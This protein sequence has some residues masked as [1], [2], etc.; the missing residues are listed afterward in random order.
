MKQTEPRRHLND[1]TEKIGFPRT[2]MKHVRG[3][4]FGL[5]AAP[6]LARFFWPKFGPKI[7]ARFWCCWGLGAGGAA[8][9]ARGVLRVCAPA[10]RC[11]LASVQR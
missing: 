6:N 3:A 5:A 1:Q 8:P 4:V 9:L 2:R 11:T 7:A 10:H